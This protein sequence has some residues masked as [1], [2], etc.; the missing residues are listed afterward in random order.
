MTNILLELEN[1]SVRFRRRTAIF[2]T[3]SLY[4]LSS[5][6]FPLFRGET[7]GIIGRNGCGKSTLL[8]I[9]AGIYLPD[10]GNVNAPPGIKVSLLTLGA[11]FD[12]NLSGADNALIGCMLLG[13]TRREATNRIPQILEF[14]ELQDFAYAP[15][16]T[17]ST[18]M[19]A[20][21][22]FSIGIQVAPDI[23]LI[24][25]V[26]GVGDLAFRQKAERVLM[27]EINSQQTVVFV[28]HNL[29]ATRKL[30]DRVAWIERGELCYIGD[31]GTAIERYKD[32]NSSRIVGQ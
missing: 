1:V 19:R 31:P 18:G 7:L 14:A 9:L 4:A 3:T 32:F 13:L 30:C 28:S 5:I 11:G 6:S 20:R 23:L 15:L 29:E 25:E 27:D 8:R 2:R 24:D 22:G 12:N 10:S 16:K 17:Y 21:L 26:L